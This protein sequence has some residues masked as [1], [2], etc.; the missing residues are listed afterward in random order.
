LLERPTTA[1]TREDGDVHPL[2]NPHYLTDP[3]NHK[4]VAE[5]IQ[6][7]FSRLRPQAAAGFE[8]RLRAFR[9]RVDEAM[10]GAELV[11]QVGGNKLDRLARAG[12][13]AEFLNGLSQGGTPAAPLG[14]WLGKMAPLAGHRI[15]AYHRSFSYFHQRFDLQ[16][17]DY[18]ERKPGI[19]PGPAALAELITRMRE[20]DV[21]ILLT[22]PFYDARI[23]RLVADKAGATVVELP[24]NLGGVPGSSSTFAFFDLVTTRLLRA[25]ES[26]P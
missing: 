6:Q 14:G 1:V 12:R 3:L 26:A 8:S 11:A 15:A 23:A 20:Q 10:F 5:T 2:G 4:L 9:S 7:A 13:L 17:V 18:V 24:L 21:R 16:V 19:Q 22:H 25:G